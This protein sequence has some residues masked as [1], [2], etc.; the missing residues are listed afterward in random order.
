[1]SAA[2]GLMGVLPSDDPEDEAW[3]ALV[4]RARDLVS[5]L[6]V[7]GRRQKLATPEGNDAVLETDAEAAAKSSVAALEAITLE[8]SLDEEFVAA[9]GEVSGHDRLMRL[10]TDAASSAVAACAGDAL[11]MCAHRNPPGAP[12]PARGG[13]GLRP[14]RTVL[15]VGTLRAPLSLH[16]RHVRENLGGEKKSIPNIAWH[17]GVALARWLARREAFVRGL[18]VLEIGAGLGA[19]GLT[20]AAFGASRVV[21]TDRDGAAVRN[22]RYNAGRGC[23]PP[24]ERAAFASGPGDADDDDDDDDDGDETPSSTARRLRGVSPRAVSLAT[25]RRRI[26]RRCVAAALDWNADE[27][28]PLALRFS[29]QDENENERGA[30]YDSSRDAEESENAKK[31]RL[32]LGADVVHERGMGDGVMRCL[33]ELLCPERGVAVLCNPAPAHRAGAAEFVATLRNSN[34]FEFCTVDV[35]SA[36]LRVGMEEETEDIV[37]QMFAVKKRESEAVLPDIRDAG[38]AWPEFCDY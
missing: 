34:A 11:Q 15:H 10:V 22:L 32:V 1:M 2:V 19:P 18:D 33:E 24:G 25:R 13:L 30:L 29:D 5:R 38:D 26:A 27:P 17:S 37:L 3:D 14:D 4:A 36:L 7:G 31:F 21:V 9:L 28:L 23:A 12:F 20:A 8:A 6:R 16:L 35:T